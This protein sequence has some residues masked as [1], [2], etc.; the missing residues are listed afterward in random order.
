MKTEPHVA[1]DTSMMRI[2]HNALRRDLRRAE[3]VLAADPPR[4]PEQQRAVA[5]HLEWMMSFLHAH[6][7]SEDEGLYP[8]VRDRDPAAAEMLEAMDADHRAIASAIAEVQA[9]AGC[10]T[11]ED[12]EVRRLTVAVERLS[13]VLL[14]HLEREENEMMPVV[15]SVITESE[16]R[17]VEERYNLAG[18]S[19][20]QLGFEGHWLIDGAAPDD[21][22]RVI[23]LVPPIPR[24]VL[25]H[26]FARSYRRKAAACWGSSDRRPRGVQMSC[27]CHVEVEADV[28]AVWDIARDV[29]R[30]GDWS[31]ECVDVKWI[32]G[33]TAAAP[34]ARFRGRNKQ[35]LF[36]WGRVC[37]IV[38]AEPYE[39]VW[40]TVPTALYPDSTDWRIT[41]RPCGA[42]TKIEQSFN[43]VRGSKLLALVYGF[44]LPAHRD[45]SEALVEDLERLGAL[46]MSSNSTNR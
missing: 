38:N 18:K 43:V 44:L 36:R 1:A 21:R 16:W 34:G 45:R 4:S 8:L 19:F 14:P 31:H 6:H 15:S 12:G 30:V 2:V 3:R 20:A 7:R 5:R 23:G 42:G 10:S 39:L 22:R 33:A 28:E 35:G 9:A 37:E 24:F 13:T 17:T 27:H 29:T 40:R 25:V 32:D 46:A 11:G 26:G 41:L